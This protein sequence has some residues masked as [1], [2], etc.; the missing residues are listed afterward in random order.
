MIGQV[1]GPAERTLPVRLSRLISV[2]DRP[3][4]LDSMGS[5]GS[6]VARP[7]TARRL[8]AARKSFAEGFERVLVSSES[9]FPPPFHDLPA[10]KRGFALEGGAMGAVL[11]DEFGCA[12]EA[13]RLVRLLERRD[14]AER[15]LIALG[16]GMA[17][18]RMGKPFAWMPAGLCPGERGAV[19]DGYGF[20]QAFF[21]AQ[22]FLG[23]GFPARSGKWSARYDRGLGRGLFFAAGGDGETVTAVV[24]GMPWNRRKSLWRGV[25]TASAFAGGAQCAEGCGNITAARFKPEFEAGIEDGAQIAAILA[26]NATE[27]TI[28]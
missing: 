25:G 26:R 8:A 4:R 10:R 9:G 6:R 7:E 27:A 3:L 14:G 21:N 5:T 28:S 15:F 18:A 11:L 24:G 19:A 2:T 17:S 1:A 20:H 12:G 16:V 23:R 22:R 13:S